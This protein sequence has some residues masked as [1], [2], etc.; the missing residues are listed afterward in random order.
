MSN[1]S[2]M[3]EFCPKCQ[4]LL[5]TE[6]EDADVMLKCPNCDYKKDIKG[7]HV[8]HTNK[9]KDQ[10]SS[11]QVPYAT[12]YDD[13]IKRTTRVK[14]NNTECPSLD[15]EQWGTRTDRGIMVE[16]NVIVSTV[17]DADRVATYIC[18]VCGQI[19]RP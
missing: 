18:R 10:T 6:K 15:T 14:C 12:I 2:S 11:R 4:T 3:L 5:L 9:Y 13:A 8:I 1:Q 17:Y 19:F 16:P 7:R